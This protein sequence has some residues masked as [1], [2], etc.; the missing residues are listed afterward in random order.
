MDEDLGDD[1]VVSACRGFCSVPGPL[2]SVQRAESCGVILA[3]QANDGVL[4][5]VDSLSVVRH[6]GRL[7]DGKAAS[8]PAGLVK[9]GDLVL[10][11]E[12]MLRLRGLDTVCISKVTGHADEALVRAGGPRELDRLG[13]DGA[14]ESA[15]LGR[16]RVPWWV[17][18]ARRN[19]SGV[20]ARWRPLVL[21]L[22]LFCIAIAR[23]VVSHYGVAGTALD[24]MVWSVG[25]AP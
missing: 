21:S 4:L 10:L 15:D 23:A 22:H 5:G 2:Q 1:A 8:R 18:D 13:N 25:G 3:L 20:C 17:I 16:R 9:D 19:Y 11:N 7:L 12:R 6:V 24:P 14:D